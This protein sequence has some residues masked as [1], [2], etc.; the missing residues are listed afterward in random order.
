MKGMG[1]NGL[2]IIRRATADDVPALSA[3]IDGFAKGHPAEALTRSV[4][5]LREAF[6]GSQPVGHVLLAEKGGIAV[7]FGAWRRTYDVYWS[8]FGGEVI[9]LYVS[10]SHRRLGTAVSIAA[11]MCAEIREHG[12][13]FLQASYGSK[14]ASMYERV[15]VGRDERACHVSA[16]AFEALAGAAGKPAREIIRGLPDK[17]WNFEESAAD[18]RPATPPD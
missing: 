6:F 17:G 7:G 12:G 11:V 4:D 2:V 3:L 13:Q 8:M 15:G 10:P 16:R 18:E 9:G 5:R 14:F 1:A